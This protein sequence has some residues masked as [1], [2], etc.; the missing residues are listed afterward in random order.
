MINDIS[1]SIHYTKNMLYHYVAGCDK[2]PMAERIKIIVSE[3]LVDSFIIESFIIGC[4]RAVSDITKSKSMANLL[5]E[6]IVARD[7][8]PE[9]SWKSIDKILG[10]A[11]NIL[12]KSY[13][14]SIAYFAAFVA[15]LCADVSNDVED[16]VSDLIDI[17]KEFDEDF[18]V[19][20]FEILLNDMALMMQRTHELYN[21]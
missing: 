14:N 3:R 5:E 17:M 4:T 6:A 20:T 10:K 21:N 13:A 18:A 2:I 12:Q 9:Y 1:A 7:T 15:S 8:Y 11:N 19:K 16:T